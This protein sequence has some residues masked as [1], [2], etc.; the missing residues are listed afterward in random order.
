M[1]S[2]L[3]EVF[4]ARFFD[5]AKQSAEIRTTGDGKVR[6]ILRLPDGLRDIFLTAGFR[7]T[8]G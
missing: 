4:V 2:G 7:Q 5:P 6:I 1:E 3:F 8:A